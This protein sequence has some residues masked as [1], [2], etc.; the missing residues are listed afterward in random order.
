MT[1]HSSVRHYILWCLLIPAFACHA[2]ENAK[3]FG[4]YPLAVPEENSLM[5]KWEKKPV[6]ESLLVDDMEHEGR[7]KVTGIG[8]MSYTQDRAKDGKQSLRFRTSVRDTAFLSLPG[9]LSEGKSQTFS[10]SGQAGV[11]SVQLHFDKP[12]DWSAFNRISYW[13]YVHPTSLPRHNI[14][15][16]IT[17]EG[18]VGNA[19]SSARSHYSN[20]LK[21]G[22]WNH[23]LFEMPHLQRDRVTMFSLTRELTGN[24]PGED[25]IVTY[26]IDRLELQRVETDQYE[27]WTVAPEKFSF[28]HIGYRPADPKVAMVGNGAGD[29]FQLIDPQDKVV[30]SGKVGIVENKN[31]MFHS[32]DFSDFRREGV[33]RIRSGSLES[34]AFPINENI[35]L[36]PLFAAVNFYFCER[37]G[38]DVPGIHKAC[39]LDWQGFR[40]DVKKVIN[41][42]WHDAG[43]LSQG[44][45]RSSMAMFAMLRN[46]DALQDRKDAAEVS[47]RMRAEIAW[48]L[49][50][51][52]K[53][54]FGD[55]YH[56]HWSRMRMY[57]DNEIGTVDDVLVPAENIPWENFLAA[58]VECKSAGLFEKSNPELAARARTAAI[59]DWQAAV[60]SRT[61]WNEATVEEASW[62]VTSSLLMA[63]M[64]GDEKYRKQA[65]L[66]GSLLTRC[67]EQTFVKGIPIT[68]YFYSKTN[69]RKVIHNKHTAFEEAPMIAL[70]MLCDELPEHENWMDWYGSAVLYSEF[71]LKRGSQISA[72]Y[73]LL[74]NSVWT[75]AEIMDDKDEKRRAISLQQ[76]NEGTRLNDES[77]LRTFPIWSDSIF[78]G[79]TNIQLSSTWALA[80]AAKLRNDSDGMKLVGKQ[81]QWVLGANPFGQSLMYGVGYDFA[82]QYAYCLKDIV[83]SLPVGMDCRSG[84]QPYWPATNSATFKEIWMEPV[85]RFLGAVATYTSHASRGGSDQ[86]VEIHAETSQSDKGIASVTLTLTGEGEHKVELRAFNAKSEFGSKQIDL[87]ANK[88]EKI[89]FE[90]AVADRNKPYVAVISVD[91]N[92]SWRKEIVGSYNDASILTR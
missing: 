35:W 44:I 46:L 43:D 88:T 22:Q 36:H 15:L 18:T 41:G 63:R 68:G 71:F 78:H 32:L 73:N 76:F 49:E 58:A 72:P 69:G 47:E 8:E 11:S 91:K 29:Q 37:C 2:Q 17:N 64:T 55:G 53:T 28:S 66:L 38:F 4:A 20:D 83:G 75:K 30:F 57:T 80:E 9:N 24:N 45:W 60:A 79:S 10:I 77:V 59:D 26:D 74:P 34:N 16:E 33:Y 92:P 87:T 42:G 25:P 50:Y 81:L 89:Q 13:I 85:S 31:G 27:G 67:Q 7:W 70:A 62:G 86:T 84:D 14:N 54:R 19:L 1:L 39:H 6:L 23:V 82:P 61:T 90:L 12:Q 5:A 51:L 21:P 3:D 40:G 56:I 52:L 65:V 48:G